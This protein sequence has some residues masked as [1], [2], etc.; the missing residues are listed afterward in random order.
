M[1]KKTKKESLSVNY[2]NSYQYDILG[3]LASSFS[4]DNFKFTLISLHENL[5]FLA[6]SRF[7]LN[8]SLVR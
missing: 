2:C 4:T 3:N 7:H 5:S 1:K 6:M 8:P